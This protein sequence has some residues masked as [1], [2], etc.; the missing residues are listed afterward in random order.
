MNTETEMPS[1]QAIAF[2]NTF[3]R[4]ESR[5]RDQLT[6]VKNS[7]ENH[8]DSLKKEVDKLQASVAV[9]YTGWAALFKAKPEGGFEC[10]AIVDERNLPDETPEDWDVSLPIPK[11]G[12]LPEFEGW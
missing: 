10:V 5:M 7:L 6:K 1:K 11:P 8:I 9:E 3:W 4:S 2:G 12:S